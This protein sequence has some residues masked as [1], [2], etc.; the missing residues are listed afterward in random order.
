MKILYIGHYREFGGW[1]QASRDHILALDRV[2]VDVVC[3]NVTLTGDREITGRLLEL[4]QK[5]TSGCDVCIQHVLP[6]H[7]VGTR[8]FR[9]NIAFVE[10]ET[11][12]IKHLPWFE[13]LKQ[14]DEVWTPN[15]QAKESLD[16]DGL[17]V[18]TTV[19]PHPC[20]IKKYTGKYQDVN[21][22]PAE[23]KFRFY[24]VGDINDR[25]NI[26]SIIT[27]FHS[28]FDA[29]ENVSLLLKVNKFG[30][31]VEEIKATFDKRLFDIKQSLRMHPNPTDYARDITII[32]ELPDEQLYG[33][34]K[35]CHCFLSPSHGEAWSIP[36]FDAMVFGNTPICSDFG[37]PREFIDRNNPDT[38]KLVGGCFKVCK[39]SDSAFPD[40]FTGREFW[41]EPDE[42][43][44]RTAMRSYYE[45][46]KDDPA[47]AK[48]KNQ[49]ACMAIA[50]KFDYE[51][52][53]ELMKGIL[54]E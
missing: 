23:G 13:H 20:D 45:A 38:G 9:K 19:V 11:L 31:S 18:P 41:F 2:G 1:A 15:R 47:A 12:S 21:I 28:E 48:R 27:C 40:M 33:L 49:T 4:E 25:K 39:C 54:N 29:S 6:H 30:K 5:D 53:G 14:A 42:R 3:R 52:V 43:E 44:I 46:G 34:H 10:T 37:G 26:D 24:Y 51:A 50:Q 32:G 17:N 16:A 7:L 22:P 36:A 35:Y 8:L